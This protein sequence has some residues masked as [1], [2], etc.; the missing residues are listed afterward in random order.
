MQVVSP[1][2]GQTARKLSG[3]HLFHYG[4]SHSSQKVRL[5]L[6]QK[7]LGWTSHHLDLTKREHAVPS[8]LEINPDGVVNQ[9]EGGCIQA[10]SWTLKEAWRPGVAGWEDYPILKFSEAPPVE[11]SIIKNQNPSLGAGEC[12]MGP[13]VAAIANAL[14][15]ALGVRVRELPL[16]ADNIARA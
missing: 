14:H 15:D 16:T 12:T 7:G 13:T 4:L 6:A 10:T 8:Y 9:I 1:L 11:V 2:I 3:L 5:V